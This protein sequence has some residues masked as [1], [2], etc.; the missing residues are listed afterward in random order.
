[1]TVLSIFDPIGK[2]LPNYRVIKADP[3][4]EEEMDSLKNTMLSNAEENKDNFLA[5]FPKLISSTTGLTSHLLD[6]P[7]L[8]ELKKEKFDLVVFGWFLN[9]FQIG[10]ASDFKAPSVIISSV[11]NVKVTRDYVGNPSE[12]SSVPAL[13]LNSKGPMTFMQRVKNVLIYSIEFV[14]VNAVQQFLMKPLYVQ[15]FPPEKYPSFDE[16][17]KNVSLVLINSHFTQGTP[18]ALVPNF[19]EFSGMHIKRQ[20]DPLPQVTITF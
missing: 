20:P 12:M 16:A 15:H 1:M 10:L 14:L 13:H 2:P 9:D 8:A 19:I 7:E 18:S 11:P 6:C 4:N 3:Y 5:V 17:K